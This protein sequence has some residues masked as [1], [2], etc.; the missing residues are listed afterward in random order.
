MT[1]ACGDGNEIFVCSKAG[2]SG[3]SEGHGDCRQISFGNALLC[4]NVQ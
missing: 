1:D 3:V 4:A 2:D